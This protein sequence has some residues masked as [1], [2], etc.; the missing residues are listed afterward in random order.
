[1]GCVGVPWSSCM[2][3][4][5]QGCCHQDEGN[6]GRETMRVCCRSSPELGIVIIVI[7]TRKMEGDGEGALSPLL[8]QCCV[9]LLWH[10]AGHR[11]RWVLLLLSSG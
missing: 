7:G 3:E 5:V 4:D 9:V 1:M 8:C 2:D 10:V 6:G 11:L